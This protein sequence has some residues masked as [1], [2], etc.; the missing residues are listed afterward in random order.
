MTSLVADI[1]QIVKVDIKYFGWAITGLLFSKMQKNMFRLVIAVRAWVV[2]VKLMIC[3]Y[4]R[5]W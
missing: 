1:L 3:H 5:S 2:L 4:S